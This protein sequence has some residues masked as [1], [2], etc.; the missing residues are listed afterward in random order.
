MEIIEGSLW[1][2]QSLG[3][4]SYTY[5]DFQDPTDESLLFL[6]QL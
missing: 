3:N 1:K 2:T 4:V 5:L 6:S